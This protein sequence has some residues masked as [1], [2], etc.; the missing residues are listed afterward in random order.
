M[1]ALLIAGFAALALTGCNSMKSDTSGSDVSKDNNANAEQAK[2]VHQDV[3]MNDAATADMQKQEAE[4]AKNQP[5]PQGA[6]FKCSNG[7][8]VGVEYPNVNNV[9]LNIEGKPHTLAHAVSASGARYVSQSG[10]EW[11]SKGDKEAVLSYKGADGKAAEASC[12][13]Q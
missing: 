13:A 5:T 12:Q 4:M 9:I 10:L 6:F 11:H 8:T 1:K 3:A 2:K 7:L